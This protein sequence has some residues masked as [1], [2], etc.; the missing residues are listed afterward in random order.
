[1]YKYIHNLIHYKRYHFLHIRL[2]NIKHIALHHVGEGWRNSHSHI[3]SVVVKTD[4]TSVEST[5]AISAKI[6][7]HV[8]FDPEIA[9]IGNYPTKIFIIYDISHKQ[10][11]TVALLYIFI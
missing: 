9:L 8:S 5:S 4:L 6:Q 11:F 1:M 2:A 10:G 7:M 3:F